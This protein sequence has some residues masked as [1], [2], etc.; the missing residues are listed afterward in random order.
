MI[1]RR[2][3]RDAPEPHAEPRRIGEQVEVPERAQECILGDVLS[4]CL[5]NERQGQRVDHALVPTNE[6]SEGVAGGR[7]GGAS[8]DDKL[9]VGLALGGALDDS[10][11]GFD[12]LMWWDL[13]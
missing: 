13:L 4:V 1:D 7:A 11:C 12:R 2:A 3:E 6:L 9:G 10:Q 5:A 8:S